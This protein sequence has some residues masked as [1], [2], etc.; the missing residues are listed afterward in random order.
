MRRRP[1]MLSLAGS[2]EGLTLEELLGGDFAR[3]SMLL[4]SEGMDV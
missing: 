2:S 1:Q 3:S 4:L